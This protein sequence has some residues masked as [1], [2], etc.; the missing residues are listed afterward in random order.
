MEILLLLTLM[1]FLCSSNH[2]SRGLF[3]RLASQGS[4]LHVTLCIKTPFVYDRRVSF[5]TQ[6][7]RAE[8]YRYN[9]RVMWIPCLNPMLLN[10]FTGVGELFQ[11]AVL[12]VQTDRTALSGNLKCVGGAVSL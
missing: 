12:V 8:R 1:R 3:S 7:E 4:S 11:L 5:C 9:H 10:D 6:A 2:H